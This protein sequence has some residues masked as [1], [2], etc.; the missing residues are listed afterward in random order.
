MKELKFDH[1][2][3]CCSDKYWD[4]VFFDEAFNHSVFLDKLGFAEWRDT[5]TKNTD[6][7]LERVVV[8]RPPVSDVPAAVRKVLGDN[9]GYKELGKFDRKTKRY[10]V[11]V[12]SNTAKDKTHVHG[13]IWLEP[14]DDHRCR[15]LVHFTIEVKI[16]MV[17]RLVEELIARDMIRSF[18][19]GAVLTNEW[20]R[21]K[22]SGKTN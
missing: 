3:E 14:I 12:E 16:M 13:D 18:E 8:V 22:Y 15:R 4:E 5:V 6:D 21:E 2:F 7:V 20:I 9:F 10:H 11:D 17:G 1:V 19:Q